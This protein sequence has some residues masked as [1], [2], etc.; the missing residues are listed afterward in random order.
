VANGSRLKSFAHRPGGINRKSKWGR[1]GEP[2]WGMHTKIFVQLLSDRTLLSTGYS[3]RH[4]QWR[5]TPST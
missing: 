4:Y 5:K 3:E 2:E 1:V